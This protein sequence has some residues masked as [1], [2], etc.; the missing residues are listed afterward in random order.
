MKDPLNRINNAVMFG[1]GRFSN[2]ILLELKESHVFDPADT[3]RL[4]QFRNDIW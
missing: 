2:G 1:R 4:A 3:E